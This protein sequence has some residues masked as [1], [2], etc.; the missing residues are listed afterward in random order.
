VDIRKFLVAAAM[1]AA[2]A[3]ATAAPVLATTNATG[4]ALILVPLT[5]TKIDDLSFGTVIPSAV[6][7][8][9][10]IN[11][12]TGNRTIAGGVT[13]VPSDVGRRGYFGGAGSPGRPVF[14]SVAS[15]AQ[16]VSTT[17]S[18]DTIDVVTLSVEGASPVK[19]IHPVN[20]TFFFG[21]GGVIVIGANQPEG[22]YEATF[23]VTA[24]YM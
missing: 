12:A 20:R 11:A 9:V 10:A 17:N 14:V 5:L 8:M 2:A 3:P 24:N 22:V 6:S 4:E 16:L 7:G 23:D 18:A 19:F 21:V 15:P 1:A 13:G